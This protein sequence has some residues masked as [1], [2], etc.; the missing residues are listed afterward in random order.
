MS[1]RNGKRCRFVFA[2]D[3]D[4]SMMQLHN[5]FTTARP[6]PR[7]ANLFREVIASNVSQDR[8]IFH[9]CQIQH[10]G[11]HIRQAE[12]LSSII[13][14]Y[15]SVCSFVRL[16]HRRRFANPAMETMGV[17]NSWE[18]LLIKSLR[19]I[20]VKKLSIV[21]HMSNLPFSCNKNKR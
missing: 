5:L 8:L 20:S 15:S 7:G 11:R 10:I 3:R 16:P 18:K 12:E 9:F 1:Y 19:S 13:A 21:Y 14:R 6:I 2:S 4:F 17:L